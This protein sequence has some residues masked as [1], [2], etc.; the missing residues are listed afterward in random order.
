VFPQF[1][2]D[3]VNRSDVYEA[4]TNRVITAIEE[5]AGEWQMPWHRSAVSRPVNAYTKK[6]YRGVNVVALW[7]AA[8]ACRYSSGFWATYKQWREIEAQ[9]RKGEHASLIVFWKELEREVED[10]ETRERVRKKTLFARASWVFNA[11]QVEGWAPRTTQERNLVE[12]IDQAEAFT[13]ATGADVRHGGDRA[14][15]RRSEDYV[16]MPERER[17]AG[18]ATS[19]PTE[20]YYA[21]L[22]HEL[23]HWTGH[24]SRLARDLSGRFGNEAYAM[25]EPAAEL[26]AAFLCADL[27][28]T[29]TPRPDHAAYI[30]NWLEVLKRDKRAIFTAARKATQA[31]DFLA[32]LQPETSAK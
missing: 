23:T 20:T 2:G 30:A 22:L 6:P 7:A 10:E 25:E 32:S 14:Y 12:A 5:G 4:I 29:N 24:E 21:T 27:C 17:F 26:G 8:D 28:V 15:Y 1:G 11:D 13:A 19:T 16:Q 18:S 9:V 3:S 31:N